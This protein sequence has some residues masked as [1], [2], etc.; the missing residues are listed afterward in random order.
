MEVHHHSHT[1]DHN[2]HRGRKKW[3]HYFWEFL[4]LFLAV[5][6]GFLAEYQLEH[7]I[8][9]ERELKYIQSLV[10]DL[11]SDT[12]LVRLHIEAQKLTIKLMDSLVFFLNNPALME[13]NGGTVYY[14]ARVA[15]RSVTFASNNKTFEQLKYAGGF[16][17]IRKSE[18]SNR[19]MGYYNLIP[20]VHQL[21]EIFNNEFSEYKKIAARIFDPE[22]FRNMENED[23][24][25]K[26]TNDNPQLQ[27]TTPSLLKELAVYSVYLNG[28]RRGILDVLPELGMKGTELI[29]Y[30]KK[31]YDLK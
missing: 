29:S 10:E 30:L 17:L 19:I 4:M 15:P 13:S 6:C 11:K 31:E 7:K 3:T 5:F 21:E 24:S 25:V 22:V 28:T 26:R 8:E 18:A 12:G 9:K 2:S 27:N 14:I 23:G 16:R 20:F 1:A